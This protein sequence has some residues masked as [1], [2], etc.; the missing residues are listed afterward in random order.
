MDFDLD[1]LQPSQSTNERLQQTQ[2]RTVA[3]HMWAIW[4]FACENVRK[5]QAKQ[6]EFAILI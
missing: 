3:D 5:A 1:G 6:P 4:E 2:A